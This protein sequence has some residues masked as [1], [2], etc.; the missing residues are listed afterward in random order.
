MAVQQTGRTVEAIECDQTRANRC[1]PNL[2]RY[3]DDPLQVRCNSE[4]II[5]FPDVKNSLAWVCKL[6][7]T[8]GVSRGKTG[9]PSAGEMNVRGSTRRIAIMGLGGIGGYIGAKLAQANEEVTFI[10]RGSDLAA[11]QPCHRFTGGAGCLFLGTEST[12]WGVNKHADESESSK[13]KIKVEDPK[14][15]QGNASEGKNQERQA[16]KRGK[17]CEGQISQGEDP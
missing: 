14:S 3:A 6:L 15:C 1:I 11:M 12:K 16:T 10:A 13:V 17:D 8:V 7:N 5:L 4:E 2:L 9:I